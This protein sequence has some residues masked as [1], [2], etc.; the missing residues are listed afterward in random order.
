MRNSEKGDN[1]SYDNLTEFPALEMIQG[2]HSSED[3]LRYQD[4]LLSIPKR[5]LKQAAKDVASGSAGGLISKVKYRIITEIEREIE[6]CKQEI[7]RDPES[8]SLKGKFAE[9]YSKAGRFQEAAEVYEEIV[10]LEDSTGRRYNIGTLYLKAGNT[11]KAREHLN[12]ALAQ[13]ENNI[14]ARYNLGV[15]YLMDKDYD[16]AEEEFQQIVSRN[17]DNIEIISKA[18][19]DLGIC[20]YNTISDKTQARKH[21]LEEFYNAGERGIE[22]VKLILKEV[23]SLD[24]VESKDD[25][26]SFIAINCAELDP[27]MMKVELF[28][29]VKGAYT[30]SID[31]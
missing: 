26:K 2:L 12:Q 21:T 18:H 5:A 1:E 27:D 6:S 8:I 7:E 11:E 13:D 14:R 16:R 4:R 10:K 17:Q 25:G 29:S 31:R 3:D 15:S 19:N 23:F 9:L 30:G 28:G 24:A 20:Y 22:N